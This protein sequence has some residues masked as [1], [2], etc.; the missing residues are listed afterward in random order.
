LNAG[1]L[2]VPAKNL[3]TNRTETVALSKEVFVD[4]L[5][6]VLYAPYTAAYVPYIIER[7]YRRDYAPLGQ[8]IQ[9]TSIG[10]SNGLNT[11]ANLSYT[12]ADWMPFIDPNAVRWAQQ[13]SF[14]GD[15]RIR[16]QQRA[17]A[18]W[19]VPAMPPSFNEPVHSDIPVLMVSSSNDPGTPAKYGEEALRYLPNGREVLVKGGGHSVFTPCTDNLI[20]QFIRARSAKALNV[21]QCRSTYLA[22]A[23]A[24]SMKGWPS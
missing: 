18:A 14:T 8:M 7:A 23:F 10:F 16:A 21:S 13:H 11:A 22:P 4:E 24:T 17:C 3:T 20:L 1:T 15:L 9:S 12:C 2:P 19:D 6:H 5:R